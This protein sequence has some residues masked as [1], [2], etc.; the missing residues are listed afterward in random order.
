MKRTLFISLLI[1]LIVQ[2]QIFTMSV[3]TARCREH[4]TSRSILAMA[5]MVKGAAGLGATAAGVYGVCMAK[6]TASMK[7]LPATLSRLPLLIGSLSSLCLLIG[8]WITYNS[9][10]NLRSSYNY[11]LYLQKKHRLCGLINCDKR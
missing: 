4:T 11:P 3:S 1:C 7:Y 8:G 2:P 5:G 10:K 6:E 9:Y